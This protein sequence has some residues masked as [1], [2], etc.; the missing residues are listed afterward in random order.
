MRAEKGENPL[1]HPADHLTVDE[2]RMQLVFWVVS[3]QCLFMFSFSFIKSF[4]VGLFSKTSL[5]VN[6]PRIAPTQMQCTALDLA[7]CH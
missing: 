6:I 7:E 3:K 5:K 4:F 1:P 2:L